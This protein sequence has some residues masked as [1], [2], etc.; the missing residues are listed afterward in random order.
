MSTRFAA[1]ARRDGGLSTPC[2]CPSIQSREPR[3]TGS[4][5]EVLRVALEQRG[6]LG[7]H[8]T[9]ATATSSSSTART[10]VFMNSDA[11][12]FFLEVLP[13]LRRRS[14][15]RDPRRL[16]AIRLSA[17]VRRSLL[18]GA[19]P[20]GRAPDRRQPGARAACCRPS[21]QAGI[22]SWGSSSMRAGPTAQRSAS[23]P[24][25]RPRSGQA[26]GDSGEQVLRHGVG[27]APV[28]LQNE[29][30]LDGHSD[31]VH[32]LLRSLHRREGVGEHHERAS[33]G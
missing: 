19:V 23:H 24:R 4:A 5:T 14:P 18:L 25:L 32:R 17:G 7:F 12:V 31:R 20:A 26:A 15:R 21:M 1:R 6:P 33:S 11:T 28:T 29:R 10:A 2:S 30:S 3:S 16:P 27:L 22:P 9:S 13:R 8:V